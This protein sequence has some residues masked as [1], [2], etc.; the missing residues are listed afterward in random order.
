MLPDAPFDFDGLEEQ[1]ESA[2][3]HHHSPSGE[4]SAV[5]FNL[6]VT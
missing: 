5:S 2:E 4:K 6:S 1:R 3:S